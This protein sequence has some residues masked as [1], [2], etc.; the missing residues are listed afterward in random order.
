MRALVL[1]LASLTAACGDPPD[2]ERAATPTPP[3]EPAAQPDTRPAD[4][5]SAAQPPARAAAEV[6]VWFARGEEPVAVIREVSEAEPRAALEALLR[7]PT[8]AEREA[9]LFSWFSDSTAGALR[10]AELR[11]GFLVVDF[12]GLDRLIPNASSS[13][14]SLLLISALDSTVFQFPTVDSVEYRLDG[15]CEALGEWLQTGCDG[16][17]RP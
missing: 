12:E 7:G 11:D 14:G 4:T 8:P 5:P 3:G 6:R 16:L 2:R 13:L 1:V 10:G 17:R 15:S 9:G